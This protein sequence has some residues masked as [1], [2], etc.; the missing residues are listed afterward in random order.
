MRMRLGK[1]NRP[2]A[3]FRHGLA[4]A[5]H[6]ALPGFVHGYGKRF[7]SHAG[8][9]EVSRATT[10]V[11]DGSRG[12]WNPAEFPDHFD[13]FTGAATGGDYVF[14]YDDL[15]ARLDRETAAQRHLPVGIALCE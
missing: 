3:G 13:D 7:E 9:T 15:F 10:A 14:D 6:R 5:A 12:D 2:G 11:D 4:P 8:D 1:L